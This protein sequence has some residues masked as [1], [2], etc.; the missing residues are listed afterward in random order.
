MARWGLGTIALV[1]AASMPACVGDAPAANNE[2]GDGGE[3]DGNV[4][5]FE[6]GIGGDGGLGGD[7]G[8][9]GDG[10]VATAPPTHAAK[11]VAF[12]DIDPRTGTV[13]GFVRIT[14]AD[15]ESDVA[16]YAVYAANDA[17]TKSS[18]TPIGSVNVTGKDVVFA[19][20]DG[21]TIDAGTTKLLVLSQ[22]SAGEMATGP[23]TSYHDAV[24]Y[25]NALTPANASTS[26]SIGNGLGIMFDA[27]NRKL[28]ITAAEILYQC[29]LNGTGCSSGFVTL[30][31]SQKFIGPTRPFFVP[32]TSNVVFAAAAYS[33]FNAI[34]ITS[35]LTGSTSSFV[36]VSSAASTNTGT[37]V[38][39]LLDTA[40]QRL[41]VVVDD[42]T[43][44]LNPS[45]GQSVLFDC[46]EDGTSCGIRKIASGTSQPANGGQSPSLVFDPNNNNY[47]VVSQTASSVYALI[48]PTSSGSCTGHD[49]ITGTSNVATLHPHAL[50][51]SVHKQL[52][53]TAEDGSG[54][55]H[56][57]PVLT[58]CA[59]DGTSCSTP[60]EMTSG[61][62][63]GEKP[64]SYDFDAV[65]EPN[66]QKVV[67]VGTVAN[68][69]VLFRCNPDATGCEFGDMTQTSGAFYS[70]ALTT[71]PDSGQPYV[72]V[73]NGS[74]P[75]TPWLFTM[76]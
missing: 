72:V 3:S 18:A 64:I 15:D 51:D 20:P 29:D 22:N 69:P 68:M 28:E 44:T 49:N 9:T 8:T 60:V 53:V 11:A 6:G 55:T 62:G 63:V 47:I 46:A 35:S 13:G 56:H 57:S 33:N 14:K 73:M 32:G 45:I 76:Y 59:L 30:A 71:D 4:S 40:R 70:V 65:M 27:T 12:V 16:D 21:T 42:G 31:G 41:I 54:A 5:G 67:A 17:G 61:T 36:N 37:A 26:S 58:H 74:S 38:D 1:A 7:G 24:V 19:I 2:A 48:C 23:T 25:A 75:Y 34:A 66:A 52:I 50:I 10:A 39:A 43:T